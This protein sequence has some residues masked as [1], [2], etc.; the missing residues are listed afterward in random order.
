MRRPPSALLPPKWWLSGSLNLANLAGHDLAARAPRELSRQEA[1]V[2]APAK[3]AAAEVVA[4]RVAEAGF[5]G[6]H[7]VD[8]AGGRQLH[9][10]HG[11]RH[12]EEPC[13]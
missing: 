5:H 10:V 8:A 7:A 4:V 11:R 2:A 1:A 9:V 13:Q 3:R 12:L 6:G